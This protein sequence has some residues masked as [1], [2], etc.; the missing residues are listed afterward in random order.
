M[1]SIG[2]STYFWPSTVYTTII[3]SY[4][5]RWDRLFSTAYTETNKSKYDISRNQGQAKKYAPIY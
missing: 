4:P 3:K 5:T 2:M 1:K